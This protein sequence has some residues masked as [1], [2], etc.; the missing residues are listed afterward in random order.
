MAIFTHMT[1]GAN[2][3]DKARKFYDA[4]LTPLGLKRLHDMDHM[5]LYGADHPEFLVLKPAN[6]EP[7]CVGNGLTIGFQAPNHAA[8]NAFH[9]AGLA[10]GGMDEGAPGPRGFAPGAYAAY[11]RDVDGH[12]ITAITYTP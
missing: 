10:A 7:A 9:A 4:V 5:A 8:V 11:L 6:G 3:L 12:K 2:D 1:L